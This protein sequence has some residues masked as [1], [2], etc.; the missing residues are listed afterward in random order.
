MAYNKIIENF[1]DPTDNKS[2]TFSFSGNLDATGE[3]IEFQ[4]TVTQEQGVNVELDGL[5]FMTKFHVFNV[6]TSEIEDSI[7]ENNPWDPLLPSNDPRKVKALISQIV[8]SQGQLHDY[9]VKFA[10]DFM[11]G[12]YGSPD[13]NGVGTP[14][15]LDAL[16]RSRGFHLSFLYPCLLIL[17]TESCDGQEIWET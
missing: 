6:V 17:K 13:F 1:V 5:L 14:S 15:S 10:T 8:S 3:F 7:D 12:G 16:Q 11:N 2:R 9:S 4:V